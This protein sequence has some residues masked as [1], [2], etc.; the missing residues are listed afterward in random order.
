M[1]NSKHKDSLPD[2]GHGM[3]ANVVPGY[4][5]RKSVLVRLADNEPVCVPHIYADGRRFKFRE[6]YATTRDWGYIYFKQFSYHTDDGKVHVVD[7][8]PRNPHPIEKGFGDTI[9]GYVTKIEGKRWGVTVILNWRTGDA[10]IIADEGS[11]IT[12]A[13]FQFIE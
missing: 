10:Q 11:P 12:G 1:F 13:L 7:V 4:F 5:L 2:V 9:C 3:H 6:V 8:Q